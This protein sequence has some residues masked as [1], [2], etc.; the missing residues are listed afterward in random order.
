MLSP[1]QQRVPPG[2]GCCP[3]SQ[4]P[5]PGIYR[6]RQAA[7]TAFCLPLMPAGN[8]FT[9]GIDTGGGGGGN[10]IKS[11]KISR[12]AFKHTR[13]CLSC[14]SASCFYP[15]DAM[16]LG[17]DQCVC[18]CRGPHKHSPST[19]ETGGA[20][21]LVLV[22]PQHPLGAKGARDIQGQDRETPL[23]SRRMTWVVSAHHCQL[24]CS[25]PLP[26]PLPA[27]LLPPPGS[28]SSFFA[29][30]HFPSFP[31]VVSEVPCAPQTQTHFLRHAWEEG[32]QAAHAVQAAPAQPCSMRDGN[33]RQMFWGKH[34]VALLKSLEKGTGRRSILMSPLTC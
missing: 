1:P 20:L 29:F 9:G 25:V 8:A 11:N 10:Q 15:H 17:W 24:L 12:P 7:S 14:Q 13:S 16:K 18:L 4:L 3:S 34:M 30:E 28:C 26:A 32:S 22:L 19:G 21:G 27:Q 6:D 23:G 31:A 5:V 2:H 33:C